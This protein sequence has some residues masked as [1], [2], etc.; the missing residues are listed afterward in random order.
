MSLI[1]LHKSH[2]KNDI[3]EIIDYANTDGSFIPPT[4]TKM[5]MYPKFKPEI[6]LDNTFVTPVNV[7]Q[8]HDGIYDR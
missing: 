1:S 3:V 4:P 2:S 5:G 7:I 6:Y 8:G